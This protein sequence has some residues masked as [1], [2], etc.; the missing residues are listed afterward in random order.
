M[1]TLIL[2]LGSTVF[3]FDRIGF[4]AAQRLYKRIR[5]KDIFL[6]RTALSGLNLLG[7]I[8]DYDR[9]IVIDS[10]VV[11]EKDIGRCFRVE[12]KDKDYSNYSNHQ[13]NIFQVLSLGK[14]MKLGMPR[15]VRVYAIGTSE[16]MDKRL[17]EK[18]DSVVDEIYEDISPHQF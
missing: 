8:V 15:D 9:L 2:G 13:M 3:N 16:N 12:I 5:D 6:R 10:M 17:E 11:K 1:K 14:K 7:I 4:A 18:V